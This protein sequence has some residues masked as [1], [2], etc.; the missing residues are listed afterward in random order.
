MNANPVQ[1]RKLAQTASD[2]TGDRNQLSEKSAEKGKSQGTGSNDTKSNT[3]ETKSLGAILKKSDITD[4]SGSSQG[5]S[6][7][8]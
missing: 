2:S 4:Q 6:K 5:E 7:S 1:L 3:E 8:G